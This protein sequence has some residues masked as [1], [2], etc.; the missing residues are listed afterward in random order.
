MTFSVTI[1]RR[2]NGKTTDLFS[3]KD[4]SVYLVKLENSVVKDGIVHVCISLLPT[5]TGH[6]YHQLL[7]VKMHKSIF[8]KLTIYQM[9]L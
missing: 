2:L 7:D 1:E 4:H 8:L 3:D 5:S 9:F 6:S